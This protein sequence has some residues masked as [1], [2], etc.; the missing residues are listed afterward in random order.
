MKQKEKQDIEDLLS[1]ESTKEDSV[2]RELLTIDDVNL[3][4]K[5]ELTEAQVLGITKVQCFADWFK[6]NKADDFIKHFLRFQ[7][8]KKR[9]GRKE[10]LSSLQSNL[11]EKIK[12]NGMFQSLMR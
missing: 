1:A 2:N 6:I 3:P 8:S 4:A 5:S 9:A 11:N 10:F 7:I 12:G